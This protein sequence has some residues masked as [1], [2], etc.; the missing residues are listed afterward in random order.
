MSQRIYRDALLSISQQE[1]RISY[2]STHVIDESYRMTMFLRE[3]LYQMKEHVLSNGFTNRSEEIEFFRK[4]KPQILGKL[5]YY[6]KLYR[7][8][9]SCPV[10]SG[11]MQ[12]KYYGGE[13]QQLKQEYKE[14]ICNSDFFRYYRS[15]RTDLDHE[16]FELGK[17]NFNGGLNSYVFEIDP[18]FSTYYDYKVSRIIANELMYAYL[19]S[20]ITP[21]HLEAQTNDKDFYWTDSKNALIELI[22]ALY[23]ASSIS[24]GRVSIRKI[25][26][27]FQVLFRINLGDIH[28]AYHRMKVRSG[29]RTTFL[30]HLKVSMEK[31]MD[32]DL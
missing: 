25:S 30:D 1:Q 32:K 27:V 23:A 17:I 13:L 4:I 2:D 7:V 11:K 8:E 29:S 12:H 14:H 3:L 18:L 28:H 21:D 26:V 19:L 9:T 24:G 5:I 15:G 10:S 20:K 31:Y 6:N 16:Y 22:Y